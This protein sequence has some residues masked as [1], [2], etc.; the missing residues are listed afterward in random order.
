MTYPQD[1]SDQGAGLGPQTILRLRQIVLARRNGRDIQ[2]IVLACGL[3]PDKTEYPRQR[4]PFSEMMKD[5]L[6][7]E[8][9]FQ[10]DMIHCSMDHTPWNCIEVTLETIRMVREKKL[11]GN[12]LVVS[13]GYH[14]YP[15][16]WTTWVLICGGKKEWRLAFFPAWEGT[17]DI[18]HELL[19]T[20]KYIPLALWHR[21]RC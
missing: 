5:W 10:A 16:M 19:G 17:Y 9:T 1:F 2:A 14:L 4:R 11:P 21:W 12:I 6:V 8:G 13:T 18:L 20:I 7:A 15:R 3:G